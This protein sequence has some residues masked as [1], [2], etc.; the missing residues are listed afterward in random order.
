M[1]AVIRALGRVN[2]VV[3]RICG[4]AAAG[5]LA[6]MLGVVVVHVFFRYVLNS[7]FGWTEELSRTMMVWMAF[8]YFP[9]A[10]RNNLNVSLDIVAAAMEKTLFYRWAGLIIELLIFVLLCGAA[11][12]SYNLTMGAAHSET[13]ALRIPLIYVYAIMPVGFA[14]VALCSFERLLRLFGNL[15]D[16]GRYEAHVFGSSTDTGA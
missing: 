16:P 4:Y 7:S 15:V 13:L 10:H 11:Y 1:N 8:F 12:Y 14:L 2:R 6:A 5:L 3:T 9:T